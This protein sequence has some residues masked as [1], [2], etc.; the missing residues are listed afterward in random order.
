MLKVISGG[1]TGADRIGLIV[2]KEL[3]LETG[4]TAPKGYRT[5]NGPNLELRDLF[6]LTEAETSNYGVRTEINVKDADLTV[7]FGDI[8]SQGTSLTIHLC[9]KHRKKY[10]A[11]PMVIELVKALRDNNVKV[12]NVAGN[13]GSKLSDRQ[14]TDIYD[15]LRSA[16]ISYTQEL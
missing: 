3:G 11:N 6:A 14:K 16:L 15:K 10:V 7:I 12:L 5:E 2:A 4:G 9:N 1:Q 13:R 8:T